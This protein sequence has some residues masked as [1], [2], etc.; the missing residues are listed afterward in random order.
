MAG[1]QDPTGETN[2]CWA[3]NRLAALRFRWCQKSPRLWSGLLVSR[4][5]LECQKRGERFASPPNL[6]QSRRAKSTQIV[7]IH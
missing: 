3:A 6:P 7:L 5:E 4:K 1:D 2:T